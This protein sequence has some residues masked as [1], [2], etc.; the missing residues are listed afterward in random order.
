MQGV[1]ASPSLGAFD[2]ADGLSKTR[3]TG[4]GTPSSIEQWLVG[5]PPGLDVPTDLDM[6]MCLWSHDAVD[7]SVFSMLTTPS[8]MSPPLPTPTLSTSAVRDGLRSSPSSGRLPS[9]VDSHSPPSGQ[10]A[11]SSASGPESKTPSSNGSEGG[12]P[13]GPANNASQASAGSGGPEPPGAAAAPAAQ[14][15]C[16]CLQRVVF[17][18][19]E[20]ET[21]QDTAAARLDAGLASHREALRHGEAMLLCGHCTARPEN[22][23]ILTFLTDRLAGLCERIVDGYLERLLLLGGASGA[24][25]A[26]DVSN[27]KKNNNSSSGSRSGVFFG[28]YEVDSASEWELLVGNLIGLQLRALGGLMAR[29]KEVA[30]VIHCDTPWRKAVG[31]ERRIAV[32]LDRLNSIAAGWDA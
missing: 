24:G 32:L 8:L 19:D 2:M 28:G 1:G 16:Q 6:D 26:E 3:T 14:A 17:L 18:I 23:T 10:P 25:A 15:A 20:L 13:P 29:V 22:M 12:K 31:T 27:G 30:N 9:L 7:P 5:S 4:T 11:N 21:A